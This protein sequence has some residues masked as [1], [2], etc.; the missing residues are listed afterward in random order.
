MRLGFFVAL[1]CLAAAIAVGIARPWSVD[2]TS[3]SV[4]AAQSSLRPGGFVVVLRNG[5]HETVRLAQ[6]TVDDAFVGFHS[7]R[8]V[9]A[10]HE[11]AQLT[12]DYDWV[13]G[14][15]YEI[16]VL[17]STGEIVQSDVGGAGES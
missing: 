9:L 3:A 12:I 5:S 11:T 6:V 8:L 13:K 4:V 15:A 14:E 16:G 1:V 2:G 7:T 17:T 10:P